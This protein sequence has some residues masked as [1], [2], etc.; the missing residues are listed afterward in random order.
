M[1]PAAF[2]TRPRAANLRLRNN[3]LRWP[4]VLTSIPNTVRGGG[5]TSF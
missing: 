3:G 5:F 1:G 4:L 2:V